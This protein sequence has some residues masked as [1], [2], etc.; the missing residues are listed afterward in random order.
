MTVIEYKGYVIEPIETSAGRWRGR[1]Q[2]AD[3]RKIKNL[4]TGAERESFDTPGMENIDPC[5][6]EEERRL[7]G[8]R[9]STIDRR[10]GRERRSSNQP[11]LIRD[12]DRRD[13]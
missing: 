8:E 12:A 13:V 6:S 11:S 1:I 10:S 2:R 5:R 9:R 7:V 4:I 3:G